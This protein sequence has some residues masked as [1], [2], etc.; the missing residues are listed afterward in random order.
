MVLVLRSDGHSLDN[1][2]GEEAWD[3]EMLAEGCIPGEFNH[4]KTYN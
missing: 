4:T 2:I 1:G 3:E